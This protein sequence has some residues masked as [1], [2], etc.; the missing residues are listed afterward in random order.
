MYRLLL[1]LFSC[2]CVVSVY[3]NEAAEELI[4]DEE[5]LEQP[6][7]GVVIELDHETVD[8]Q[9]PAPRKTTGAKRVEM[10][11]GG[12]GDQGIAKRNTLKVED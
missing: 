11:V 10:I 3:A 7:N 1:G 4:L 8:K 6:G 9:K 12:Q 5:P 2:F